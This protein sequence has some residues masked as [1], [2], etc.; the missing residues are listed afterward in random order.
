[1]KAVGLKPESPAP[2]DLQA[3]WEHLVEHFEHEAAHRAFLDACV[4]RQDLSFAARHYRQVAEHH[5]DPALR[6]RARQELDGLSGLAWTLLKSNAKP[7]PEFKK[8]TTWISVIVCAILLIAVAFAF[9][10]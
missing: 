9:R 5:P 4:A 3:L 6:K 1:M 7:V 10:S 8:I 2:A